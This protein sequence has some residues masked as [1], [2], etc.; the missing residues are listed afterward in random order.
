MRKLTIT[1]LSPLLIFSSCNSYVVDIKTA[2]ASPS[3]DQ[4][5][6][7]FND[8]SFSYDSNDLLF[9]KFYHENSNSDIVEMVTF[10]NIEPHKGDTIYLKYLKEGSG[11]SSGTPTAYFRT[12]SGYDAVGDTYVLDSSYYNDNYILLDC[13]IKNKIQGKFKTHFTYSD[14][15]SLSKFVDYIPDSFLLDK[16]AFYAKKQ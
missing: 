1:L 7:E 4:S 15:S 12:L 5:I 10:K 3:F 6:W 11:L 14:S 16:G 2:E 8:A 13:V 9:I